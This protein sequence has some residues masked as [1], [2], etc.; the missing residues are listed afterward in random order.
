MKRSAGRDNR[1]GA[2]SLYFSF[3]VFLLRPGIRETAITTTYDIARTFAPT[4]SLLGRATRRWAGD[5]WRGEAYYLVALAGVVLGVLLLQYAAWA[6]LQ[7]YVGPGAPH[8]TAFWLGQ[9]GALLLAGSA[10]GV[11]FAPAVRVT[12]DGRQLT[13]RR[14]REIVRVDGEAIR[15]VERISALRYHRHERRYAATRAF[16]GRMPPVLLALHTAAGLVVLGLGDADQRDLWA[17]LERHRQEAAPL[18]LSR[19][20]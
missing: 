12:W 1:R 20:G 8:E 19:V 9:V 3:A 6:V 11:G 16:I 14:G 7:P 17:R 13:L 15:H 10:C 4:H 2:R 18:R 5:A